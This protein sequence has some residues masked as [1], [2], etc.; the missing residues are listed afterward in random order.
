MIAISIESAIDGLPSRA[1]SERIVIAGAPISEQEEE[2]D[3]DEQ[4]DEDQPAV[5]HVPEERRGSELRAVEA[6]DRDLP[7]QVVAP[8]RDCF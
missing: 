7:G 5:E 6:A 3:K 4:G 8:A 2:R 1:T